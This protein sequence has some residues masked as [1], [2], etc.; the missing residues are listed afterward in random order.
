LRY[1]DDIFGDLDRSKNNW[2][3]VSGL[4]RFSQKLTGWPENLENP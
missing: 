1:F 2:T 3:C 4:S